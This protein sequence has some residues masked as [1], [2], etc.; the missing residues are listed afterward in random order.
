MKKRAKTWLLGLLIGGLFGY[1]LSL[2]VL[3]F[4]S[5]SGVL[6][7][8]RAAESTDDPFANAEAVQA[9]FRQV[10]AQ[11]APAVVEISVETDVLGESSE[12]AQPWDKF[13]QDPQEDEGGTPRYFRS[14][15][16]GSGVIVE[17]RGEQHYVVTN[18]HVISE[19]GDIQLLFSDGETVTAQVLGQDPRRDLALLE[20]QS[21]SPRPVVPMANSDRLYVGDWVMAVG[22]PYGYEQSV[23]SGIISALGRRDGPGE[24]INDFIQT[25]AAINQGNSGGALVNIRGELVGINTFIT[26]PNGGSV[27]LGFAIPSNNVRTAYR[28]ILDDGQVSY[29]WLGASLGAYGPEAAASM[30]REEGIMVYQVFDA[31]PAQIAGLQPGDQILLLNDMAPQ[32]VD[33]LIYRLGGLRPGVKAQLRVERFGEELALPIIVGQRPDEDQVRTLHPGAKPG[34]LAAPLT[35]ELREGFSLDEAV[36]G[37]VVAEV[38]PRTQAHAADLRA[39]DILLEMNGKSIASLKNLYQALDAGEASQYRVLRDHETL[40]LGYGPEGDGM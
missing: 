31:S 25:D 18:G 29:G 28:Q 23:S 27:G 26:T 35:P 16:L 13:F 38:Y 37:V 33:D 36:Q 9:A 22:S 39:G 6:A 20:F 30:E 12:E 21:S 10:S 4:S 2:T 11:V 1:T 19:D 3:L 5:S 8:A 24:N 17:R 40:E 34:F 32:D 7:Q 14:Q 15:G